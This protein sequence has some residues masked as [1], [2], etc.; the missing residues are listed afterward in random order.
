MIRIKARDGR[1]AQRGQAGRGGFSSDTYTPVG[2]GW[3]PKKP[4]PEV[5]EERL[6]VM[7][8]ERN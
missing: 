6:R 4:E 2:L 3:A 8:R 7:E 1:Q 5:F